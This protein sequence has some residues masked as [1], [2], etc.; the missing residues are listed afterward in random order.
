M[1]T[2]FVTGA[3]R[4]IGQHLV[5]QLLGLGWRVGAVDFDEAALAAL[6]EHKNLR[7]RVADVRNGEQLALA[8]RDILAWSPVD[9]IVN[10]AGIAVFATQEEASVDAVRD[11]FDVN[12]LGP[13]RVTQAL[14]PSVRERKGVIVNVSS[15]AGQIVFPESGFYAASKHAV[16]GM[17]E[18]LYQEI[19]PDGVRVRLV[20]PGSIATNFQVAAAAISGAPPVGSRYAERRPKWDA[21]RNAVF[22]APQDPDLVASA[23]VACIDDPRGFFRVPVGADAIR[24]LATREAMTRDAWVERAAALDGPPDGRE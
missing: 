20:E 1:R 17:T 19:A 14:L 21:R 6:P 13:M 12:V 15:I 9:V 8:I 23:I 11:L 16:E 2:A 22:G 4:G 7:C 18:A 10:N 24:L 5:R 3:A